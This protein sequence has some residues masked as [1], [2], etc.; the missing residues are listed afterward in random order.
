MTRNKLTAKDKR[1]VRDAIDRFVAG[2]GDAQ[3]SLM[4]YQRTK[5][6]CDGYTFS[7]IAEQ[8]GVSAQTV[9]VSVNKVASLILDSLQ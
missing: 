1:Q 5:Q 7:E 3:M 8:E 6:W 4:A 2:G 9:Q